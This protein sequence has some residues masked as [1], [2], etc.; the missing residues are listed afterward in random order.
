M[1]TPGKGGGGGGNAN[2]NVSNNSKSVVDS[3]STSRID[4]TS[5]STNNIDSKATAQLQVVGLDNIRLKADSAAEN[6]TQVQMDL[7][8]L[9][10]DLCLRLGLENLPSSRI[11]R[12]IARH[13]GI[14]FMGV[15]VFGFNYSS[16]ETTIIEDMR[17]RPFIVAD[18]PAGRR[19]EH[20]SSSDPGVR[21][22]L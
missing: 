8:P 14:T 3:Q 6:R 4:S 13:F 7:K 5:N 9:Q 19:R 17:R 11:C 10:V 21:I 15:E 20:S 12:P 2:I 16:E 22:S 1:S 18:E